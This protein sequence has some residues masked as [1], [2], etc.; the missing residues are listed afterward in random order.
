MPSIRGIDRKPI[1]QNRIDKMLLI[2]ERLLEQITPPE[3]AFYRVA[4]KIQIASGTRFFK[5]AVIHIT[6]KTAFVA[7]CYFPDFRL[8][9]EIDGPSHSKPGAKRSDD[10]RAQAMRKLRISTL[11]F[12]NQKATDSPRSVLAQTVHALLD[13]QH[14]RRSVQRTL[15]KAWKH[16]QHPPED[17]PETALPYF[18]KS[19]K[20]SPSQTTKYTE[21]VIERTRKKKA[22]RHTTIPE[23]ALAPAGPPRL[24]P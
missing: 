22:Q 19:R 5:Q 10:R 4:E 6:A 12:T 17:A 20:P 2:R 7:D 16:A 3:R 24:A 1:P 13:A 18:K 14:A 15:R 23:R 9:V 21:H 11:R 8:V